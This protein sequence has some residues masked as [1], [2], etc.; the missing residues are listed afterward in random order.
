MSDTRYSTLK[1]ILEEHRRR[2]QQSLNSRLNDIRA[3]SDG[4]G[5]VVEALDAADASASDLA[6]D[7]DVALAE[8]AAQALRHVDQALG[9]LEA[10]VYGV[11]VDCRETISQARL[12]ALPFAQRCRACEELR[13]IREKPSR[14]S[15]T[16]SDSSLL[17]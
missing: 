10:G 13:E 15:A 9:R 6:Q 7:F 8:M 4:D 17:A 5:K 12:T 2:L 16:W 1:H 3:H 14:R 11:C